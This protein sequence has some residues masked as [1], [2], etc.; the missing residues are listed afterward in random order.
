MAQ[1][2]DDLD[3]LRTA[4]VSESRIPDELDGNENSGRWN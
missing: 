4:T 2:A 1:S 3:T